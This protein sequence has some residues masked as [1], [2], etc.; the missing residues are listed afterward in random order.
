[1]GEFVVIMFYC[2]WNVSAGNGNPIVHYDNRGE[3]PRCDTNYEI[4][5]NVREAK[6][7]KRDFKSAMILVLCG[8]H[9]ST[10][11]VRTLLY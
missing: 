5:T 8:Y 6:N 9:F 10:K 3:V 2:W 4:V 1:M 11:I 7:P